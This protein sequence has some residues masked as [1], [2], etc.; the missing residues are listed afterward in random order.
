MQGMYATD[1]EKRNGVLYKRCAFCGEWKPASTG[2]A[3][4][5]TDKYGQVRY[6]DDCKTCSM[7]NVI[8]GGQFMLN[9]VTHPW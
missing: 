2:F 3:K 9:A 6:R 7:G 5:G 1:Y 8:V 4:N